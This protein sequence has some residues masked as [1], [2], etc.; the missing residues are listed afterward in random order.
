M[1]GECKFGMITP[2]RYEAQ[3]CADSLENAAVSN[4]EDCQIYFD[5]RS[6]T[7]TCVSLVDKYRVSYSLTKAALG[8]LIKYFGP[9]CVV[10]AANV[11]H[12]PRGL[13]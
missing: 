13:R 1:A 7:F 11:N 8:F 4:F 5:H 2:D 3:A 9:S 10:S 6:G 12:M